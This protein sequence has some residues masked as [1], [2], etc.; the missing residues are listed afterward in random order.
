MPPSGGLP[1]RFSFS[2]QQRL[3][4]AYRTFPLIDRH[5]GPAVGTSTGDLA[6][7]Q[8]LLELGDA[9]VRPISEA[10]DTKVRQAF[11]EFQLFVADQGIVEPNFFSTFK[12]IIPKQ[13][14]EP[15]WGWWLRGTRKTGRAV[16][17]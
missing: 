12:E 9:F 13:F 2:H 5:R 8:G 14:P 6:V 10:Y 17:V 16:K 4:A 11:E 15:Y 7:G 1:S 3:A